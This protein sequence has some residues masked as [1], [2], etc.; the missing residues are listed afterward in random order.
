MASDSQGIVLPGWVNAKIPDAPENRDYVNRP[1]YSRFSLSGNPLL[2]RVESSN[3]L[4]FF[5][6]VHWS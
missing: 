4:K 5:S 3:Y 1:I 6:G 2:N